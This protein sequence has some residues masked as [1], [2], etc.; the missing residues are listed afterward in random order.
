MHTRQKSQK[1]ADLAL[2]LQNDYKQQR[3]QFSSDEQASKIK[4]L[5]STLNAQAQG[6]A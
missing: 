3:Q 6:V 4:T 1:L 2:K 5:M